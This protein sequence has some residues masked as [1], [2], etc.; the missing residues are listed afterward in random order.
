M[1]FPY[2]MPC[3]DKY[4]F[5]GNFSPI[6]RQAFSSSSIFSSL[7]QYFISDLITLQRMP[8]GQPFYIH[9][10]LK[11]NGVPTKIPTKSTRT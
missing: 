8:H 6:H 9:I 5:G 10:I 7:L 4:P 11:K 3:T 1:D 2:I